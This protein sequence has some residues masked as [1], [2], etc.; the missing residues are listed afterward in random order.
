MRDAFL[1]RTTLN[2]EDDVLEA[3]KA[4]A[5]RDRKPL[6]AVVSTMLRRAVEP[7]AHGKKTERNGIPLFPVAARARSVT[8]QHIQELLDAEEK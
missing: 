2:I 7:P 8:P 3:V 5:A 4:V 6:G 1:V